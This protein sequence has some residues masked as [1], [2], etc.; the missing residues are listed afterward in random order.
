MVRLDENGC[1]PR[2][3]CMEIDKVASSVIRVRLGDRHDWPLEKAVDGKD[4]LCKENSFSSRS[5]KESRFH[6]VRPFRLLV[7]DGSDSYVTT[8]PCGLPPRLQQG[9]AFR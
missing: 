6:V 2:Y 8:A 1:Y 5:E 7:K 3:A 4:H 9:I